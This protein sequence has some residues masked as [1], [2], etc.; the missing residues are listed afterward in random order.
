MRVTPFIETLP[1][2]LYRAEQV[3]EFDRIAIQEFGIPGSELMER[4]GSRAFQLLQER[5]PQVT[6]ITVVC[7]AGNNA[8]DGYVVARLARQAGLH[9]Q[10][11][12]L[13]D[14]LKLTGDALAM[15]DAWRQLGGEITPYQSLPRETELIVDAIL[16]TGLE[17]E[18][19]GYWAEAVQ[20]SMTIQPR[21]W[22]STSLPV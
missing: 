13:A 6:R 21:C 8:G 7:G 19:V 4:A 18:V 9:V 17:R 14:P 1:Y 5:W 2:A 10:L 11:L 15:A 12:S 16:G 3:R 20:A 22:R